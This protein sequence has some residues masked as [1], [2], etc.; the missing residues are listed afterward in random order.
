MKSFLSF[1]RQIYR[2]DNLSIQGP[3]TAPPQAVVD[4]SNTH[5]HQYSQN[6]PYHHP[7]SQQA[8][9]QQQ[10]PPSQ[11]TPAPQP[12]PFVRI[13]QTGTPGNLSHP[14]APTAYQP[15]QTSYMQPGTVLTD[16]CHSS[17]LFR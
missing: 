12:P 5:H 10:A 16:L 2:Q 3:P 4:S 17:H 13:Y 11:S 8:Q 15:P 6:Q 14:Y 7:I 1:V 9:Q